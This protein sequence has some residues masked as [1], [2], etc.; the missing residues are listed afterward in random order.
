MAFAL[1][2]FLRQ[3]WAALLLGVYGVSRLCAIAAA[4]IHILDGGALATGMG[5]A[6]FFM[7][8]IPLPF[9]LLWI[10]TGWSAL[11]LWRARQAV[12]VQAI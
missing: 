11:Q 6:A 1:A 10:R 7:L 5:P 4:V 3:R 12:D 2:F 8:C 9:A